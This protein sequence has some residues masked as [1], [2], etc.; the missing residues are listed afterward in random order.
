MVTFG[1]DAWE[2][3]PLCDSVCDADWLGVRLNDGV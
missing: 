1:L 3:V 2:G